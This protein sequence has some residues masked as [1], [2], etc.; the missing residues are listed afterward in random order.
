MTRRVP[1]QTEL[2]CRVGNHT[3]S[4][5]FRYVSEWF[6]KMFYKKAC[7]SGTFARQTLIG[8]E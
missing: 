2:R 3:G 7:L 6:I 8:N 1:W 5:A 4:L